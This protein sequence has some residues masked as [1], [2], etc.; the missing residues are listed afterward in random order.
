MIKDTHQIKEEQ[1]YHVRDSRDGKEDFGRAYCLSRTLISGDGEDD[2]DSLVSIGFIRPTKSLLPGS[3]DELVV[4]DDQLAVVGGEIYV[5]SGSTK[6]RSFSHVV[7]GYH[8][9][10]DA[11]K[12][13]G[14]DF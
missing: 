5:V 2:G 6:L 3:I 1:V 9:M 12:D 14:F 10:V 13:N 7:L 4:T 11:L 8:S